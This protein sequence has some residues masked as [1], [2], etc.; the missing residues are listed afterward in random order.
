[1]VTRTQPSPSPASMVVTPAPPAPPAPYSRADTIAKAQAAR[2]Q[3]AAMR[4]GPIS[5]EDILDL[6]DGIYAEIEEASS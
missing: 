4:N 2:E 1:M 3:I 5:L 6:I